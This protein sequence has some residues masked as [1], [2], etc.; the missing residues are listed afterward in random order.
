[1]IIKLVEKWSVPE[2]SNVSTLTPYLIFHPS[3]AFH[4]QVNKSKLSILRPVILILFEIYIMFSV[5]SVPGPNYLLK[6]GVM[7]LSS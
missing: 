2:E 6:A 7:F 4:I 3:P 1:M 5:G